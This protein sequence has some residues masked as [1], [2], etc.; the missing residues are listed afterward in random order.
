MNYFNIDLSLLSRMGG[1]SQKRTHRG[2]EYFPGMVITMRL[3]DEL[4]ATKK[5][6]P[7]RCSIINKARV[8]KLLMEGD[9][10]VGVS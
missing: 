9:K 5:A 4:E 1:H 2:K 3:L 7:T 10:V 6:D 8:T